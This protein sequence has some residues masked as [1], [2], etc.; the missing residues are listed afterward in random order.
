[1]G[2]RSLILLGT[3]TFLCFSPIRLLVILHQV[4]LR[5]E[6]FRLGVCGKKHGVLAVVMLLCTG[7]V[8]A[9][10]N[11]GHTSI[12]GIILDACNYIYLIS[13]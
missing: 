8:V 2:L 13:P 5:V 7:V 4:H 1:M 9:W 6:T 11:A 12:L 10:A 3:G